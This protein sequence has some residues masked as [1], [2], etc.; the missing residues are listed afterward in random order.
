MGKH[1]PIGKYQIGSLP[2]PLGGI[3]VYLY[4][5][6]K[7]HSEDIFL[8]RRK[9]ST[10]KKLRL[11]CCANR[12]ITIHGPY[13]RDLFLL[14]IAYKT[15]NKPYSLVLH[16][17]AWKEDYIKSNFFRKWYMR[18]GLQGAFSIQ[19]VG[20][21]IYQD[22][23]ELFPEMESKIFIKDAFL[24]PPLEDEP[25]ILSTYDPKMWTFVRRNRP[26][27]VANAFRLVICE[28]GTDL[29]GLDMCV[30]LVRRL[31]ESYPEVGLLFAL[32]D[33]NYQKE[34]L[35]Q[36]QVFIQQYDLRG[37]IYFLTGQRELW[38]IFKFADLMV[39]PTYKDGYGISVEEAL[40]FQCPAIASDVCER[41]KGT[42][43]FRN[44][45]QEDFYNKAMEVL[46]QKGRSLS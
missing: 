27:I 40:Y 30:E 20:K 46:E 5:L 8:N 17:Q 23:T 43:L 4:R 3:S 12:E 28:D 32:A 2:P 1:L 14:R 11:Y 7:L 18:F 6:Q 39:R 34:Y 9:L 41:A 31:K 26:L 35:T 44:R 24:P 45:D 29:Y 38:P 16:G 22:L 33:E 25:K 15:R 10:W 37:N 19:V 13:W 36:I 42:V 21:H